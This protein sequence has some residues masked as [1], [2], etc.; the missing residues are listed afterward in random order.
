M[1]W[2]VFAAATVFCSSGMLG[3]SPVSAQSPVND[4]AVEQSVVV[5]PIPMPAQV[6]ELSASVMR[7]AKKVKV[8][9]KSVASP[10]KSMLSRTERHQVA[11]LT[12]K[13][14][15]ESRL[16][17]DLSDNDDDAPG[18]DDLDMHRSFARP[19]VAKLVDQDR[20]DEAQ[21]FSPAV[22]LR[23]LLARMRA[24]EV[25]AM[26]WPEHAADG[27][28]ALS[29]SVSQRLAEARAKAVQ[30]HRDRFA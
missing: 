1:R 20:D 19:R 14:S 17:H 21:G 15:G 4:A 12:S 24:V 25:H 5:T 8:A 11:L 29:D 10:A 6:T 26:V 18:L 22:K 28:D 23:L 9:A 13:S 27:G 7:P 16:L 30:A 2:L 3:S